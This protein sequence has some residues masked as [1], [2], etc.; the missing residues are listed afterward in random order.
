MPNGRPS[1][2][3]TAREMGITVR[4]LQRRLGDEGSSFST[5]LDTL[6]RDVTNELMADGKQPV[7]DISFLLGYSEPSAFYRA[8]RRWRGVD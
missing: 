4:T 8:Y 7:A 6:R 2:E 5:V 1:I 3:R